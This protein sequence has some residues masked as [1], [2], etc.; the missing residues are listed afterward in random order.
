MKTMYTHGEIYKSARGRYMPG[1]KTR[2]LRQTQDELKPIRKLSYVK[3][4]C[5]V[6]YHHGEKM[7]KKKPRT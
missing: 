4:A 6:L 2:R 3:E 5:K 1:D 7:M